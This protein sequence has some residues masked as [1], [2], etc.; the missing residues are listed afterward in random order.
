MTG[1]PGQLAKDLA[2]PDAMVVP[3]AGGGFIDESLSGFA[4]ALG[5]AFNSPQIQRHFDK[6][7][8]ADADERRLFT[9]R[10]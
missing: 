1:Y 6:L 3:R 5:E 2:R 10:G 8:Q 7:A 9:G 4:D